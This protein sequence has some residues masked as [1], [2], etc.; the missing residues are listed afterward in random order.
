MQ[1][2]HWL[3]V[4]GKFDNARSSIYGVVPD[5]SAG[6]IVAWRQPSMTVL[7]IAM[8]GAHLINKGK[9]DPS[10][11]ESINQMEA[12][13]P[14]NATWFGS[15]IYAYYVDHVPHKFRGKP[16]VVFE[17]IA[18]RGVLTLIQVV[19]RGIQS[20]GGMTTPDRR[21]FLL[22]GAIGNPLKVRLLG[23]VD[24]PSPLPKYPGALY[25]V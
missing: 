7:H 11:G 17:P 24:C 9:F 16:F 12:L 23:F 10:I 8:L 25:Y 1:S 14:G 2:R 21:F 18:V 4:I 15:G 3:V 19:A 22:P 20:P 13:I 5:M 6:L